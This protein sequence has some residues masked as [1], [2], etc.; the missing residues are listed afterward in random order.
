MEIA[1]D[2]FVLRTGEE[3]TPLARTRVFLC[4][5]GASHR[6]PFC[7]GSHARIGFRAPAGE[8]TWEAERP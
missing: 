4:R 7:D 6:K 2:Q 5:C 3:E 8:L 1:G